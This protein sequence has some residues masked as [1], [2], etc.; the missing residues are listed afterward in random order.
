MCFFLVCP[1]NARAILQN[2]AESL[3]CKW[4]EFAEEKS[5]IGKNLAH[6]RLQGTT[7]QVQDSDFEKKF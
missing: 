2:L 6:G 7:D 4:Q 1:F 5:K 3:Y